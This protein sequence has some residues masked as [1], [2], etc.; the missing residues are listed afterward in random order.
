MSDLV[1]RYA[2][3]LIRWR[4]AVIVVT[5]GLGAWGATGL[6]FISYSGDYRQFFSDEN[7]DLKAHDLLERTYV[8]ADTIMFVVRPHDGTTIF[9]EENLKA[10]YD[11]TEASWLLP[12]VIRVDSL[13][14]YQHTSAEEDDLLVES[15]ID[16]PDMIT[17]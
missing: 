3:W 14:T 10:V 1:V 6:Q 11:L 17:P 13:S 15:L 2:H 4:W 9:T 7:P 12:Y 8:A 5:I 16:D